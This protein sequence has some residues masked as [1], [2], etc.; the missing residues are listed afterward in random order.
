MGTASLAV[1]PARTP[2]VWRRRTSSV[3]PASR[4]A[5]TSPTQGGLELLIND[6]VSLREI[7]A[8]LGVSKNDVGGAEGF[9]HERG[10]FAGECTLVG[11]VHVLRADG[12][13][14]AG[15]GGDDHRNGGEGGA[16]D[17][18]V[19][20]VI[21]DEGQEELHEFLGLDGGFVHLPVGGD[22]RLT[23]HRLCGSSG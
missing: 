4:S 20:A 14:G 23:R 17:D 16:N 6:F 8:A 5:R 13:A 12:D 15:S 11:E 9:E 19:A 21:G 2:R 22:E 7:L 3:L 18:L 10:G 1:M